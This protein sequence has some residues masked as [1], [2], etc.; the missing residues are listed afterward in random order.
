MTR[1]RDYV[2]PYRLSRLIRVGTSC[3]VW[4]ALKDGGDERYALKML[5]PEKATDRGEIGD[6]RHEFEVGKDLRHP[7]IIR[8]YSLETQYQAPFLALE[9]YSA[10]N[11]KQVLREG[12]DAIAHVAERII[13]QSTHG[14]HYMHEKG[15]IHC[16]VKPD[17]FLVNDDGDVKVI[18]F[19]ISQRP[20]RNWLKF[21]GIKSKVKGTRTYM[22]PEQIRGETLDGRSDVYSFACVVFELLAGRPPFTGSSPNE[23]LERHLKSSVPSAIVYNKNVSRDC[24][25][26][27]RRM[28]SKTRDIRPKS[29]W[30]VLQEFRNIQVFNRKPQPPKKKLSELDVGP[31]TDADQ[32]KQMPQRRLDEEP[33]E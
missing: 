8:I 21:L 11:L 18:D 20:K 26:L 5:K 27:L 10:L 31:V 30:E 29:M 28:M 32:L 7:N 24:A 4:E 12:P 17:N 16:D 33:E 1:I 15:W 14:L 2:G 3:Q 6:L 22:S 25:D 23:L 13:H 9:L 19:T